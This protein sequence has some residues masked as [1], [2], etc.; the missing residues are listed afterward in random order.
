M[1]NFKYIRSLSEVYL[2]VDIGEGKVGYTEFDKVEL[3]RKYI[4]FVGHS[5]TKKDKCI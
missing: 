1:E 2:N 4:E 3:E 5:I